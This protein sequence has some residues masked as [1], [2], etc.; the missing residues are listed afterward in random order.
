MKK[1]DIMTT[2][3]GNVG[4]ACLV[5]HCQSCHHHALNSTV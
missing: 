2:Y 5:R 1:T 4:N 3:F